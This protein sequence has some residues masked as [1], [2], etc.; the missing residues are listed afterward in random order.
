VVA[1]VAMGLVLAAFGTRHLSWIEIVVGGAAGVVVYVA[2]LLALRAVT[3]D[4]L[5]AFRN[6]VAGKFGR[7]RRRAAA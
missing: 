2:A 7:G 5:R 3:V 6:A 1:A 4:E